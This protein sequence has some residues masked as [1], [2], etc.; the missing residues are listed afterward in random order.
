LKLHDCEQE[1][2]ERQYL[3]GMELE[4]ESGAHK[5]KVDSLDPF[6]IAGTGLYYIRCRYYKQSEEG[7]YGATLLANKLDDLLIYYIA[8]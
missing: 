2:K 6:E 1:I 8:Y 5:I 3:I 4:H 7:I